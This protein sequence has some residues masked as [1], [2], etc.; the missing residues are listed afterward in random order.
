M[1]AFQLEGSLA[2]HDL[3]DLV[4]ELQRRRW[5]GVLTLTHVG[6]GRSVTVLDGRMVFA[7][8]SSLDDRLG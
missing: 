1:A 4:Q 5:S 8:S 7:S 3:P 2:A 6:V